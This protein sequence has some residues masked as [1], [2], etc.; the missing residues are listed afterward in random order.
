MPFCPKCRY[1]YLPTVSECPDCEV[2]LVAI[3]PLEPEK[4]EAPDEAGEPGDWEEPVEP[5]TMESYDNWIPL[6]RF[7]SNEYADMILEA[8]E[9]KDIPAVLSDSSGSMGL[10]HGS[11]SVASDGSITLFVPEEFAQDASQEGQIILGE[12]WPKVRLV[13]FEN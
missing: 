10:V 4:P 13:N 3:L 5:E 8:L 1:E 9:S 6:A 12:L 11:A 2:K 7:S